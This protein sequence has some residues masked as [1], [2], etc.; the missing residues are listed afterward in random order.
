MSD[1]AGGARKGA[2]RKPGKWGAK[3]RE[4][5]LLAQQYSDQALEALVEIAQKGT[6]DAARVSA[7]VALLDRG[8]GKPPQAL[9]LSGPGDGPIQSETTVLAGMS[10]NERAVLRAA[11][12]RLASTS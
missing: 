7:A 6:S 10:A 1:N 9:Q 8:F 5:A 4:I 2:G 11:A 12:T 3:K